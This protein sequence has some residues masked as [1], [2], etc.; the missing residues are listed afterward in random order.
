MA[1]FA[2]AN[3]T[4]PLKFAL[5]SL[6]D[7]YDDARQQSNVE[8]LLCTGANGMGPAFAI[9]GSV[10]SSASEAALKVLLS[11]A[12][13]D[14]VPVPFVGSLASSQVLRNRSV[15]LQN[16]NSSTTNWRTGVV[17]ARAGGEDELTAVLQFL[18]SAWEYLN[19]TSI[20]YED[21]SLGL[22]SADY[23]GASL[24]ALGASLHSS[25]KASMCGAL[26]EEMTAQKKQ[27]VLYVG[28]AVLTADE[29]YRA[30]P[31]STWDTLASLWGT[32]MFTQVV[33]MP[34]SPDK[35]NI[36]KDFQKAMAEYQPGMNLS[37]AS[38]EGFIAGRLITTAASR[39]LELS[40][41][42]LTRASFLD[43]IFRDIR[44][45]DLHGYTLG[46]Y[47]DGVGETGATQTADDWCNQGA[48]QVFMVYMNP[49]NG[50][51]VT[52]DSFSLK[53]SGCSVA[54]WNSTSR[55]AIVGFQEVVNL[56]AS[57]YQEARTAV[58]FLFEKVKV[59]KI[60]VL[61]SSVSTYLN[62]ST[63]FV[64]GIKLCGSY[65]LSN[66]NKMLDR[67]E[68]QGFA[69]VE[70]VAQYARERA[71]PGSSFIIVSSAED[72]LSLMKNISVDIPVLLASSASAYDFATNIP[73]GNNWTQV[74]R[75]SLMPTLSML[76]SS[77]AL[78]KDMESWVLY[79][80]GQSVFEGFF[81]GKFIAAVIESMEEENSSVE[82][83]A[84]SWLN[85]VYA[86]KYF[87]IDNKV[88]VG[89]FL[90]KN[91]DERLCNQGMDTVYVTQL[92]KTSFDY[93]KFSIDETRRCGLEFDPPKVII[94]S[95][96]NGERTCC[97][98]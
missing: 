11:S 7:A 84:E 2:F 32:V 34:S 40:G 16:T 74:Y 22:L 25:Y 98:G 64:E 82:I 38:L 87:K 14:G 89:P 63:D 27:D 5:A 59:E 55:M 56:F 94:S 42:P 88:S 95:H 53:F 92:S 37:H 72:A 21:S 80:S 44:T 78:R 93:V 57:Y 20:F 62:I 43:A 47:G 23:L 28:T 48:H 15:V 41:W 65:N 49:A 10:G 96:D 36:V 77:N 9:A 81:V 51:P 71:T 58:A 68:F 6:D 19:N 66:I 73:D 46:P 17:L 24:R 52:F 60:V 83:T 4:M 33:P 79:G 86:K 35:Y 39:A 31:Q 97:R 30:V 12:G 70:E 76:P 50:E 90:D 8:Q 61:W 1:A 85:A 3:E 29:L 67:I 75:T 45:F 13:S 54:K 26:I 91:S 18:M 69:A